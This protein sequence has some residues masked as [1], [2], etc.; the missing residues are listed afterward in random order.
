MKK[1]M[2]DLGAACIFLAVFGIAWLYPAQV[3]YREEILW[4]AGILAAGLALL[5]VC[6]SPDKDSPRQ[7]EEPLPSE[8]G[9]ITEIVLL[10]EEDTEIMAW[11]LY[12]RT[13]ALIGREGKDSLADID[14]GQSPYAAMVDAE[15]AVLNYS[16]GSWYV[17]D[18]GSANGLAIK[19]RG[20]G[21]P[22][23]LSQDTPCRLEKGD[24]LMV[25]MNRLLLR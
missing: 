24:C 4:I 20:E 17:E 14:L 16:G 11:D 18:L 1:R 15:H 23:R 2:L 12:G 22:Y 21:K 8:K 6:E 25:G 3:G 13:S 7:E 5:A 19:K 10:S 9:L